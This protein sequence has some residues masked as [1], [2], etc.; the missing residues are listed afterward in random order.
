M[1]FQQTVA[2]RMR[3]NTRAYQTIV[4]ESTKQSSV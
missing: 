4:E 1:S 3:V 2:M